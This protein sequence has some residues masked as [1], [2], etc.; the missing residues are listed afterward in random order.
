[1]NGL[2][3]FSIKQT[4]MLVKIFRGISG[5]EQSF[6]PLGTGLFNLRMPLQV[7]SQA[8]WPQSRPVTST[9]TL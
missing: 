9:S 6:A 2:D 7:I 1:M 3:S 4:G 5:I 8:I